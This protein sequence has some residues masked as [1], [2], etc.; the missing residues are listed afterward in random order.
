M[1]RDRSMNQKCEDTAVPFRNRYRASG[2]VLEIF[3]I[4][5]PYG[6][7]DLAP[8]G[9]GTNPSDWLLDKSNGP[10]RKVLV[11][12]AKTEAIT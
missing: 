12:R 10:G 1:K 8:I 11:A 7:H 9:S 3:K 5:S 4:P 2:L 6:I